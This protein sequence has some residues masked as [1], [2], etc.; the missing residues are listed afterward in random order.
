MGKWFIGIHA[1]NINL[2]IQTNPPLGICLGKWDAQTSLRFWDTNG[3]PNPSETIRP[4]DSQQKK[5]NLLNSGL[6]CS[7]WPQGRTETKQKER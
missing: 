1:K 4:N 6:C 5:E 2:T 3:S 7:G